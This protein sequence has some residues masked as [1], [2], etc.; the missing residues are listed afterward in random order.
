MTIDT[1]GSDFD[2]FLT[3]A[4]GIAVNALTV[5]AQNNDAPGGGLQSRITFDA[6][7]GNS[8]QIAVDGFQDSTGDIQL[9]L[10]AVPEPSTLLLFASGLAGLAAWRRQRRK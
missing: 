5:L 2:T 8:Y 1:F 7:A 10:N 6:F 3:L 9:Q 4:Q